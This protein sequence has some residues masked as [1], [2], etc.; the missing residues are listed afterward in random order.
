MLY[1][2]STHLPADHQ[3]S[4]G[5]TVVGRHPSC[6]VVLKSN[7]VSKRH[8]ELLYENGQL[9]IRDTNSRNSSKLN[10]HDIADS[11]WVPMAVGDRVSIC[12]I[13]L[14]LVD[15]QSPD[16]EDG[17]CIFDT[18]QRGSRVDRTH[19]ISLS[20]ADGRSDQGNQKLRAMLEI[21]QTLQGVPDIEKVLQRAVQKLLEIFPTVDRAAIGFIEGQRFIPKWW[22]LK[23][24][25]SESV[26]RVSQTIVEH[27]LES[28]Q[29]F[30]SLDAQSDFSDAVSIRELNL[31]SLMCAPLIDSEGEVFGLIHV[32]TQA[33]Q[34]FQ[35]MDL[36]VLACVATQLSLAIGFAKSYHAVME[37]ALLRKDVEHARNVQRE[38]LPSASPRIEGF[39]IAGFYRA[40]RHVGGDYYD[41]IPLADGR[42]AVVLGDV[43]GKGVPAALT[44]VRLATETRA[45]LEVCDSAAETLSRLN[46]RLSSSFI[47]LLVA[48]IDPQT[49]LISVSNAGHELPLLRRLDGSVEQVGEDAIRCPLSVI[50]DEDY[51][52]TSLCLQPGESLTLFS[53]GFP[54]AESIDGT[55]FGKE[56]LSHCIARESTSSREAVQ[57]IVQEIDDFIGEHMQFDDMCLVHIHRTFDR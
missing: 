9:W 11:G 29:A 57:D 8:L 49:K 12:D 21:T 32:D 38:Y 5:V 19:A 23:R 28:S 10:D 48:I 7:V 18:D 54:D 44:M 34:P 13:E 22:Q 25:D 24:G 52:E 43:V 56:R 16:R 37:D 51:I 50:E 55:R 42:L 14:S 4:E 39:D 20:R 3:L 41:Y 1:L 26:I 45:S 40:A 33:Q 17:S 15:Q 53:D 36:E 6:D 47:T 46:Q 35:P 31:R 2:Q 30:I 27:V